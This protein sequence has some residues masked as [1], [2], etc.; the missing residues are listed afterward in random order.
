M[1]DQGNNAVE[2]G[3]IYTGTGGIC[4]EMLRSEIYPPWERSHLQGANNLALQAEKLSSLETE[5]LVAQQ[6][7]LINV[8]APYFRTLSQAAG[9]DRH[10]VM[11][12]DRQAILLDVNRTSF[13]IIS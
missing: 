5:R 1:S 6:S 13:R 2:A 11:L 8:A 9:T 3:R 12:T 7:N 4:A 10:A